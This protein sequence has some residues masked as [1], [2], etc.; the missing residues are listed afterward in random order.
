MRRHRLDA[1]F[2]IPTKRPKDLTAYKRITYSY[3]QPSGMRQKPVP[4]HLVPLTTSIS[5]K[6]SRLRAYFIAFCIPIVNENIYKHNSRAV[7]AQS[8]LQDY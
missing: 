3:N 8:T 4:V 2:A 6:K 7:F 1:S 5:W